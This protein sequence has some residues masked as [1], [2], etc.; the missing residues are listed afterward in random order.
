MLYIQCDNFFFKVF[1]NEPRLVEASFI[2]FYFFCQ[3]L[4][5]F[6]REREQAQAGEEQRERETQNPKQAPGSTR[7]SNS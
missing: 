1:I 7:G 6:E 3:S 4:F 2:F 5:I